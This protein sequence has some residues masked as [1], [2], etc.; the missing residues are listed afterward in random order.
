MM[1][2]DTNLV[3][4]G[5]LPEHAFLE[6]WF[7]RETPFVSVVSY[8]EALGYHKLVPEDRESLERFF[9]KA[10]MLEMTSP[11]LKEAVRLR[12]LRKMGLGDALIAG[13]ALVHG[14]T[15]ATR[16]TADFAWISDLSVID[17]FDQKP[18]SQSNEGASL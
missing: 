1:L 10:P 17:P 6:A 9:A 8:V 18:K 11:V 4:Y 7:R 3:I 5:T 15:L 13:T 16:N 12:Q 14:L 2:A